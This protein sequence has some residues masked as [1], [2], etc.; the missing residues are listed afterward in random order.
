MHC[1]ILSR[2]KQLSGEGEV[3]NKVPESLNRCETLLNITGAELNR[4]MGERKA[5][6]AAVT[7]QSLLRVSDQQEEVH[8]ASSDVL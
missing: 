7:M 3:E 2:F 5:A 6:L 1:A 4:I 8:P